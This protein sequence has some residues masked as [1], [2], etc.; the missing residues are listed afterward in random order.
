MSRVLKTL[1]AGRYAEFTALFAEHADVPHL[2]V[3]F[4][5]ILELAREQLI[6]LAQAEPFAPIYVQ[7]RG[8]KPFAL[9]ADDTP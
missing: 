6:E 4:L 3:T 5:A 1:Q 9:A 2:V 7:G 8:E